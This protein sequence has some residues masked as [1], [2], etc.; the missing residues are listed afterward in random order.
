MKIKK[1]PIELE[2]DYNADAEVSS[3][4]TIFLLP[5]EKIKEFDKILH[6]LTATDRSPQEVYAEI[7]KMKIDFNDRLFLFLTYFLVTNVTGKMNGLPI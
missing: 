7:F 2:L 5:E 6:E 3:L 4:A 1:E